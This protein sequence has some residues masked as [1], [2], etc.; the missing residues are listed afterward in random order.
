MQKPNK[1]ETKMAGIDLSTAGIRIG[2]A[3]EASAGSRPTSGYKNIPG[4]KSIPAM[5]DA[6][7]LLDSTSLNA[8]KYKTYIQGL[9]DLGGGDI[10][11]T[12]N[13]TQSFCTVWDAIVSANE[14]AK[15]SGKRSWLTFYVPGVSDAF[16][17]PVDIVERGNP[18][19]EVDAVLETTG[20]F[21]PVGEP[22]FF[23]AVNPTDDPSA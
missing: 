15:A 17:I 6:P 4:P 7:S 18:G 21:I 11:I 12:F 23:T 20:H 16:F 5:D 9:R 10:G 3:T 13:Y 22:G 1:E 19:A 2:I 8:T 14:T